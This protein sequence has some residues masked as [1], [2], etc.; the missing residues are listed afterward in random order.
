MSW[1]AEH[2]ET[3]TAALAVVLPTV[4][5]IAPV[6]VNPWTR[7]AAAIG[8]AIN[9][10]IMTEVREMH[11]SL[12]QHIALD[13]QRDADR[14]RMRVLRFNDELIHGVRHTQEH[15]NEVLDDITAYERYCESHPNYQ[16][17]KAVM[18]IENVKRTYQRCE[19]ERNFL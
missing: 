6:K 3:L 16:N 13:D 15:F 19:D 8:R 5:Q 14:K 7:L 9:R 18:A 17:N 2:W 1:A 4:V 10:E 11:Q 12:D